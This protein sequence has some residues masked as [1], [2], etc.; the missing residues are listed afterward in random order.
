MKAAILQR[1]LSAG[2]YSAITLSALFNFYYRSISSNGAHLVSRKNHN[3]HSAK[4]A[5][6]GYLC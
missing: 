6:R 5:Q 4:I 3:P 1:I 2:I